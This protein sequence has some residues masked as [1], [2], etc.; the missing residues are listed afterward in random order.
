[1]V[2]TPLD[3]VSCTL[4]WTFSVVPIFPSLGVILITHVSRSRFKPLLFA[5]TVQLLIA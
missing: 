2:V 4:V 5:V 1:M 3:D